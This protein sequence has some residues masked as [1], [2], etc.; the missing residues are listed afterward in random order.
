MYSSTNIKGFLVIIRSNGFD[1]DNRGINA[2]E[3]Y[4]LKS[5]A[6]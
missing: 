6:L 3:T 2:R 5:K 1:A 4:P